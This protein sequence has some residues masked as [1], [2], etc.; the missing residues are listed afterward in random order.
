[1]KR[2]YIGLALLYCSVLDLLHALFKKSGGVIKK[3][4]L[5]DKGLGYISS[6]EKQNTANSIHMKHITLIKRKKKKFILAKKKRDT[7]MLITVRASQQEGADGLRM[8]PPLYMLGQD[9]LDPS[10]GGSGQSGA[11]SSQSGGSGADGGGEEDA[12]SRG[13]PHV[14]LQPPSEEALSPSSP[15]H[16]DGDDVEDDQ[17]ER[18]K[19]KRKKK[20]KRVKGGEQ[21][22]S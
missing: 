7:N 22:L 18:R 19:K 1:M 9:T 16:D 11:R 15:G 3:N 4:P 14:Q 20:K 6:L 17:D 13:Q 10:D 2:M 8:S 21:Q 12:P 5:H